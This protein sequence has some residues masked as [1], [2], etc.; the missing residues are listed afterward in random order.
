MGAIVRSKPIDSEDN[1]EEK[2]E[3][4]LEF[5]GS[6]DRP[7]SRGTDYTDASN[8]TGNSGDSEQKKAGFFGNLFA[9]EVLVDPP[10]P[11]EVP[12]GYFKILD[13]TKK[14]KVAFRRIMDYVELDTVDAIMEAKM[15]PTHEDPVRISV[16]QDVVDMAS[17]KRT[18]KAIKQSVH[19]NIMDTQKVLYWKKLVVDMMNK[20]FDADYV[21]KE[22]SINHKVSRSDTIVN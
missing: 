7:E 5:A 16:P 3:N 15:I 4:S 13:R 1:S 10:M 2:D 17:R 11:N 19:N 21:R 20:N 9:K 8:A 22:V 6:L 14:A 18:K 12:T